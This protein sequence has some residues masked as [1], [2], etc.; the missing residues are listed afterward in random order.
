[1]SKLDDILEPLAK[2]CWRTG[3]RERALSI[4]DNFGTLF[5]PTKQQI[6]DLMLEVIGE[7]VDPDKA[8]PGSHNWTDNRFR[9]EQRQAIDKL[10]LEL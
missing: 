1:M 7:D 6:K 9:A 3:N 2:E 8:L 10:R 5:E 4:G